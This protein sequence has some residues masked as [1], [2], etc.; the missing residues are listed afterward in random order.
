MTT[1]ARGMSAP[2]RAVGAFTH[3]G[4]S[5]IDLGAVVETER[6]VRSVVTADAAERQAIRREQ[7][8]IEQAAMAAIRM[9]PR[10]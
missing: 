2:K 10:G 8:R 7:A 1:F 6:E 3:I 5:V 4:R 9:F